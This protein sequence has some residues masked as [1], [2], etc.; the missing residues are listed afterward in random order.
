LRSVLAHRVRLVLTAASATLG[1][2]F[3]TGTLMLTNAL[4]RTFT[5]LFTSTAQDVSVTRVS[6]LD[7]GDGAGDQDFTDPLQAGGLTDADVAAV[8]QV[9]GVAAAAG[10]VVGAGISILDA[11]GQILGGA[12][13]PALG[14]AW[15][16]DPRLSSATIT[17]GA[18]PQEPGQ[19]AVDEITFGRLGLPL[20][21]AVELSVPGGRLG[22]TLVGVFR[23]GTTGGQAGLT[24]TALVPQQAQEVL[25]APGLWTS[26]VVAVADGATDDEVAAGIEEALGPGYNATTREEQISSSVAALREGLGFITTIIGVFAGIALFVAAFLIFN[27]FSML[28]AARGRELA[29]LRAV[30][31]RRRQILGSVLLEALVVAGIAAVLGVALGYLLA[32]GLKALLGLVGLELDAGITLTGRAVGW[33]V[34]LAVVVTSLSALVPAWRASRTAPVAAMRESSGPPER[35]GLWRTLAGAVLAA[36]AAWALWLALD[37][38]LDA[39]RTGWAAAALLVGGILLAPALAKVFS[40]ATTSIL[41]VVGGIPGRIAGRNAGR[42]PGR[43]AAT[44]AALMIGLAL[45]TG[46]S[47]LVSSARA[48]IDQLVDQSFVGDVLI[49]RGGQ[50]FSPAIAEQVAAV[51][52]VGLVLQSGGGPARLE[53]TGARITVTALGVQGSSPLLEQA[54]GGLAPQ[55]VFAGQAVATRSFAA[56]QSLAAGDEARILLPSGSTQSFR[57]AALVDDNPLLTGLVVPL[58]QYRAA[59]GD[60]QDQAVFVAFDGSRPPADV[61]AD[62]EQLASV[63]PGLEVLNATQ[64]KERNAD[65]LNQFLYLVYALLG[66]SIVIAAL[67]VVNTMALSVLERT[68]EIGLLRA[69]GASR[70]Q[71]RRMVR[72]EAVL[73]SVL[74]GLLGVAIGVAAGTALRRALADDG[75]SL[76]AIPWGSL[77]LVF[78]AAVLIGVLGAVLPGRRA[79]RLDILRAV[80]A[81]G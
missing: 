4:D 35:P 20:G 73:V 51:P 5:D 32:V 79:S 1:V 17:D 74:G 81:D 54:L 47:V 80:A 63:D 27:T 34:L 67:G 72:W 53:S 8:E 77:V 56:E 14:I 57:V 25:G 22:T 2:A 10:T 19:I 33:A 78:A 26:I 65:Q 48:S 24:V 29:L 46:V 69:V 31:A 23:Q 64:L 41:G 18:P 7:S 40:A 28:V 39:T 45:V 55:D 66:L 15:I 68:R 44:A 11:Q 49:T 9:P 59:G 76:L 37:G 50:S 60:P 62:V 6:A 71:I 75:L 42:A 58:P 43:V 61:V 70:R 38:R 3:I 16:E 21:S 12:G 30:G 36:G 13:P 52:G